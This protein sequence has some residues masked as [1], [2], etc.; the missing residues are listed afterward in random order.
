MIFVIRY[1]GGTKL[2]IPGLLHAYETAAEDV[3]ENAKLRSWVEKKD[4]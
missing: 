3:I 2:G 4:Y 1:F